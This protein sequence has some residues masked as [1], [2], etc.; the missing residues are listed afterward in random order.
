MELFYTIQ[1]EGVHAG[2][3][4]F[5]IR[6]A[7][8]DIG[9]HWCDVK[10]SWDAALHKIMSIDVIVEQAIESKAKIVVITGGEPLL[11]PLDDLTAALKNAGLLTHLETAGANRL[12]GCWDWVCVSPKK[13][14]KPLSEN[15]I[16]A[17]ELK[18]IVYNKSD[19][20]WAEQCEPLVKEQCIKLLQPEWGKSAQ[21]N[22][23]IV[24]Y[25]KEHPDWRISL[26]THKFL[27]IP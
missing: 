12:T 19:L 20:D 9:C 24:D 18:V 23:L 27:D 3:P 26:Q 10:E 13:F 8:C 1:G 25:A 4:A 16:R 2:R 7:G 11:Y 6:L 22:K 15:L 17:D 14:K 5:F 21:M